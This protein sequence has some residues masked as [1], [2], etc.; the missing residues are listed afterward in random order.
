MTFG[1]PTTLGA[2]LSAIGS[3]IV[4]TCELDSSQVFISM[5]DDVDVSKF[6]PKDLF[7][8]IAPRRGQP[9]EGDVTGGGTLQ[10]TVDLSLAVSLWLRLGLDVEYQDAAAFTHATLSQAEQWKALITSLQT[11]FPD[12]SP[13]GSGSILAQPMRLVG[14]EFA[15]RRP[16]NGW[17]KWPTWWSVP[18]VLDLGQ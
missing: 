5:A 9:W 7:V 1:R 17:A 3:H 18:F 15:P 12:E 10:T 14:F 16:H 6:P 13:I 11:F 2:I 4:D 8:Q